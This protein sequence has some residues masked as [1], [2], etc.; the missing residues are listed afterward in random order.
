MVAAIAPLGIALLSLILRLVNLGRPKGF[1]F[2]E[3]YYV[4]GARD[5]L[6]HG[7][8]IAGSKAE[9]VVHPPVGKWFIAIGIQIFGDNEFG[10]RFATAV[11]GTHSLLFTTY[12]STCSSPHG[13][14]W[15]AF[16]AFT[17]CTLRSIS[18]LLCFS[19]RIF[20]ASKSTLVSRNIYRACMCN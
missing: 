12:Y 1:V 3:V 9:F 14:G 18:D 17:N 10:W 2:D 11:F 4:D 13:D 6:A 7:V 20:L 19:R 15:N 8:E 5:F 16:S